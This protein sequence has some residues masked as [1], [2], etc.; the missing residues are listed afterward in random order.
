MNN[1]GCPW[2]GSLSAAELAARA[3]ANAAELERRVVL[4]AAHQ[5]TVFAV[6][7]GNEATVD[8]ADHFVPV[9]RMIDPVH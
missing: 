7:V 3:K 2:G 4:A 6:A 8:W 1:S 9:A 5:N